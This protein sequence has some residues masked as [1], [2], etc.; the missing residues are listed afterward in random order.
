M[1]ATLSPFFIK[2]TIYYTVQPNQYVVDP[3]SFLAITYDAVDGITTGLE[4]MQMFVQFYGDRVGALVDYVAD[5]GTSTNMPVSNPDRL[6]ATYVFTNTGLSSTWT[7]QIRWGRMDRAKK[8]YFWKRIYRLNALQLRDN[9]NAV[10]V[11]RSLQ[12][13]T[14]FQDDG[15]AGVTGVNL[16][17]V[18]VGFA[19]FTFP[20]TNTYTFKLKN[21]TG[22][23]PLATM[24]AIFTNYVIYRSQGT[25]DPSAQTWITYSGGGASDMTVTMTIG[26][27]TTKSITAM[28]INDLVSTGAFSIYERLAYEASTDAPG[29][30]PATIKGVSIN[31]ISIP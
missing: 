5:N 13:Q 1:A 17:T 16:L 7:L 3:A 18:Q 9:D 4:Q 25:I 14:G 27:D 29:G 10:M 12:G 20:D 11:S 19:N 30:L 22:A 26:V 2:E 21:P 24:Q 31:T 8:E 6:A 15:V 28:Q 23:M